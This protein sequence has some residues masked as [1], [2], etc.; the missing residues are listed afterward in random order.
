MRSAAMQYTVMTEQLKE[1]YAGQ[2]DALRSNW[3]TGMSSPWVNSFTTT[4]ISKPDGSHA[5]IGLRFELMTSAGP[6]GN[7]NARLWVVREE[8]FWRIERIWTDQ[9]LYWYTL[10]KP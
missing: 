8:E 4:D 2:L 5:E 3:V 7:Y 6:S 9:E 1:K 10:Y